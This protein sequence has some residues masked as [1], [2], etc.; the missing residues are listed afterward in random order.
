MRG[1]S[2]A[3]AIH[4][5]RL[6]ATVTQPEVSAVL[7]VGYLLLFEYN[8]YQVSL[9]LQRMLVLSA[10]GILLGIYKTCVGKHITN[11]TI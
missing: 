10:F 9:E 4:D 11:I 3:C 7:R 8:F 5:S 1:D 6:C 2:Q